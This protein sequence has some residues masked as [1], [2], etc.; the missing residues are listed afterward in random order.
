MHADLGIY[1]IKYSAIYQPKQANPRRGAVSKLLG[2]LS[3]ATRLLLL[4]PEGSREALNDRH[5]F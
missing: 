1:P 3:R 5:L 4:V 2:T